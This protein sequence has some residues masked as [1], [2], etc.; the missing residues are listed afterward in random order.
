MLVDFV[1]DME[2][3]NEDMNKSY[4]TGRTTKD[5]EIRYTQGENQT[6]V[7]R[8]SLA[9][10]SGYKDK[11]RTDFF[12]MTAWGK[13]AETMEKY[14]PKGT[15][16]IVECEARQNNYTD[17]NGNKVNTVDFTVLNFEFA[18]SKN[19]SQSERP[20]PMPQTDSDGFMSIP[21]GID[22]QLPFN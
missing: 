17:R 6:A 2:K 7:G 12:N 15:K 9:V 21:D 10:E 3:E 11:K 5:I 14:V 4:F 20:Q 18:E 16:I 1:G 8:F 22:E 19:V 13:T